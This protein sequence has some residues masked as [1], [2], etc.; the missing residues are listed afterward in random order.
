MNRGEAG[1]KLKWVGI[2]ETSLNW[3][4]LIDFLMS[5]I[6]KIKQ[7]QVRDIFKS[8][9]SLGRVKSNQNGG[10]FFLWGKIAFKN[11]LIFEKKLEN[12]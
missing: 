1:N 2:C 8:L 9:I 11:L 5:L 6:A 4:Y 12:L 10:F 3:G 7:T